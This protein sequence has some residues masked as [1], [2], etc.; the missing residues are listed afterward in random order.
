MREWEPAAFWGL[1]LT[2]AAVAIVPLWVVDVLPL[3]DLPGHLATARVMH[4]YGQP[5]SAFND[6]YFLPRWLLP[7]AVFFYL[8]DLLA[9]LMPIDV[10]AKVVFSVYAALVPMSL[11]AFFRALGHSRWLGLFGLWFVYTDLMGFGFASF[12]LG[13]PA[14]FFFLAA[15]HRH[16]LQPTLRRDVGQ[17]LWFVGLYLI[18]AQIFLV[19]GLY[20]VVILLLDWQ[21]PRALARRVLPYAVG[22]VPFIA[23]ALRFFVFAPK[24]TEAE[25]TFGGLQSELGF[26]WSSPAK[27]V[28]ELSRKPIIGFDSY[29]DE[30]AVLFLGLMLLA[31]LWS[32]REPQPGDAS[33]PGALPGLR[34]YTV[35]ILTLVT[36]AGFVLLPLHMKGQAIISTRL[37]PFAWMMLPAWGRMPRGPFW[38]VVVA[39]GLT[40]GSIGFHI[41][42]AQEF[43]KYEA[44]ELGDFRGLMDT[45]H[46][47]DRLAYLR[48]D[49][50][51]RIVDRGASW[52]LDS[53]HMVWNGGLNRMPFHVI[54]PHH[55]VVLPD[56]SPPRV[57]ERRIR[58]FAH[59]KSS[60]WYTH[61][62][63]YSDETPRFGA[64]ARNLELL[65]QS[66]RLW[67][68]A[69]TPPAPEEP[70]VHEVDE[71]LGPEP[72]GAG[73][74]E[75]IER[76][77][78]Q[79][80]GPVL[81][82]DDEATDGRGPRP[83]APD[84][85]PRP[86]GPSEGVPMLHGPLPSQQPR[87]RD[88][89]ARPH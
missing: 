55:T 13:T 3:Q 60:R 7:N 9:H 59:D 80:S 17:A 45:L 88:T 5:G 35:E 75:G 73:E 61:V 36:V 58:R 31:V 71:P 52:Y 30:L 33:G 39:W 53:Y 86:P 64:G 12:V 77:L 15:A 29:V 11:A 69:Y 79:P 40:V 20:T 50:A 24:R 78:A 48:P 27:L 84:L 2:G 10:G 21:G 16:A 44:Q 42:V 62:L 18:H 81:P 47:G 1:L 51:H 34:R 83:R 63:V 37:I 38:G 72:E 66:G 76:P 4:D 87:L 23:W 41:A 6:L 82:S 25:V 89:G 32:R 57:D 74:G 43:R 28:A 14:L 85:G 67:L 19:A 54:F 65:G 26:A 56:R 46:P 49:R 70:V 8:V 68:Y 22:S